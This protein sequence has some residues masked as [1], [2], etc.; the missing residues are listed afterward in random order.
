MMN[1]HNFL[2]F[3]T[4]FMTVHA[5]LKA[6]V[7]EQLYN[8]IVLDSSLQKGFID[9]K[10]DF[11]QDKIKLYINNLDQEILYV[12]SLATGL[13]S[14]DIGLDRGQLGGGRVVKFVKMGN[15]IMLHQPNYKFRALTDNPEERRAVT[16][17]FASSVL[18][19]FAIEKADEDGFWI[20]ATDFFMRDAHDVIGTLAQKKQGNYKLNIDQS[21]FYL[22]RTKNFPKNSEF[23]VLLTFSGK[24][25][26]VD[27]RSVSPTATQLSLRQHHSFVALPDSGY[28]MRRF[29]PRAGFFSM[30]YYDYATPIHSPL[31][32]RFISRHRLQKLQ[33]EAKRSKAVQPIVYYL[34]RAAPEP[35]RTALLE[36]ASWWNQAFEAA[37]YIDAFRIEML[38]EGVDPMDIRYNVIQWV[39]RSTRGWSYGASIRDPRTGEIIKGHVSLGSLRV[40]QDYLIAEALL[41]PY[42][43]GTERSKEVETMALARIRQLAAHEVGHTLGLAH[44]FASSSESLASVMDY[45]HPLVHWKNGKLDLSAAYDQ[46][47][48]AWDK[49][50]IA[51]GYQDFPTGTDEQAELENIIQQSIK[52]GL[53]FLSD[54]DARPESSAHPFAHL[55]DN[56]PYPHQQLDSLM[57]IRAYALKKFGEH[58]L[59]SGAAYAGLEESLVPLYFLHR[60]QL[61]ATAKIIGGLNYRYAHRGDGQLITE[62]LPSKMQLQA[63]DALIACIQPQA[64]SL[65]ETVLQ[66]LA[67]RA[68]GLPRSRELVATRTGLSFDALGAA[69]TIADRCFSL[70]LHPAR[71]TRLLEYKARDN[72]QLAFSTV[73]ERLVSATW[74]STRLQG[75]EA[76]IQRSVNYV[77]LQQLFHLSSNAQAPAQVR[78]LTWDQINRLES[79]LKKAVKQGID[80]SFRAQYNYALSLII[81]FKNNPAEFKKEAYLE[82]PAGSPIGCGH[83]H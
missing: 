75:Y 58:N 42:T 12:N 40:R 15:K 20:D 11:K 22:D 49:V 30:D 4:F 10:Y 50:S 82:A 25:N 69:E 34:D 62:T 29:D 45:P 8:K 77:L 72:R 38:P 37:G 2:Y 81:Q 63:L 70:I 68:M 23:E 71:C 66:K 21:A 17:A 1:L 6:Q 73:L 60:Y 7:K 19:A 79:W 24:P 64:L 35:L 53:S 47:I 32:K 61:E 28:Q 31:Q 74:M 13:G 3:F 44:N 54:Q 67:P 46:K 36:G 41:A 51:Y 18:W 52:Q 59:R 9:F 39:H 14:N 76:E 55:W 48:G 33:P 27:V 57:Q 65:P 56:G 5:G 16:D 83:Q 43:K 26:S 78:A 80:D